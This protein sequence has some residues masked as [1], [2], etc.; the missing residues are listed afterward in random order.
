MAK[1]TEEADP[2]VPAVAIRIRPRRYLAWPKDAVGDART[3]YQAGDI[4]R[5]DE[6]SAKVLCG[7]NGN[8]PHPVASRVTE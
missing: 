6:E 5:V 8:D 1:R 7:E 2:V 3:I 4:V